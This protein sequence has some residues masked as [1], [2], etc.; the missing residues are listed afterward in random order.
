MGLSE[1][2][3]AEPANARYGVPP[4]EICG[5]RPDN[6]NEKQIHLIGA[7]DEVA[8]VNWGPRDGLCLVALRYR[9][10]SLEETANDYFEAFC[11]IRLRLEE[12]N[13]IPFCYGASLNVYPSGMCREMGGGSVAYRLKTGQKPL[14]V[15]LIGIFD[16]GPDVIPAKVSMQ[17]AFFDDWIK[18]MAEQDGGHVR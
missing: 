18:K 17:K 3:G 10:G 5:V 11:K 12:K 7:G 14:R 16:E 13:L 4:P 15:D 2:E 6:M 1:S 8:T 9:E